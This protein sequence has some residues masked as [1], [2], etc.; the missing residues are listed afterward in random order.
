MT[1]V[2]LC[3]RSI[4]DNSNSWDCFEGSLQL[5]YDERVIRKMQMFRLKRLSFLSEFKW[6]NS[7]K[8]RSVCMCEQEVEVYSQRGGTAFWSRFC[9]T[10]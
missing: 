2:F 8:Y 10:L 7:N 9:F 3:L 6:M 1:K 5:T 4:N